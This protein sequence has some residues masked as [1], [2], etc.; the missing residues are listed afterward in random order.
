MK[1]DFRGIIPIFFFIIFFLISSQATAI[2]SFRNGGIPLQYRY[3]YTTLELSTVV[4][5]RNGYINTQPIATADGVYIFTAGIYD[6]SANKV[7]RPPAVFKILY[8]GNILWK[9]ELP[10][11]VGYELCTPLF[12][13][14]HLYV[15]VSNGYLYKISTD[16]NIVANIKVFNGIVTSSPCLY[17]NWIVCISNN[18]TIGL[19]DSDSMEIVTLQYTNHPVYYSSPIVYAETIIFG[20][21]DGFVIGYNIT[22]KH[23]VFSI[24]M[25]GK[26]RTT[27]A[28]GSE[29]IA[30]S[31]Y[32][33]DGV[34]YCIVISEHGAILW[35]NKYNGKPASPGY[36]NGTY[37]FPAGTAIYLVKLMGGSKTITLNGPVAGLQTTTDYVFITTNINTKKQHSSLYVYNIKNNTLV[38]YV[39]EPTEWCLSTP[40][41]YKNYVITAN[42]SGHVFLYRI[43]THVNV[44][45]WDAIDT[46]RSIV[47]VTSIIILIVGVCIIVKT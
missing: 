4:N 33:N 6:W 18:G 39:M 5:L 37:I 29:G 41:I 20:T 1:C 17:K 13:K 14:N 8:N 19:V 38:R 27:G 10:S 47:Y 34:A 2:Y 45:E 3:D 35:E 16:G 26:I 23:V 36:L 31:S 40:A 28:I 15:L 46:N 43:G 32:I 42:D 21:D 22:Q 7:I 11:N 24:H 30:I 44:R 9:L 25:G 12:T